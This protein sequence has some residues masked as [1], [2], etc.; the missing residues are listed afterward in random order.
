MALGD[1]PEFNPH[2][3]PLE[4]GDW[5]LEISAHLQSPNLQSPNLQSPVSNLQS[6]TDT[7]LDTDNDGLSDFVEVRV[8]TD[9]TFADTDEDGL[10]DARE[11]HGFTYAGKTWYLNPAA[12]DSN[13]DGLSDGQEWGLDASGALRTTP[14]DTD[15]DGV[16]DLFDPDNDN[17]G[18]P[19]R[20]D[21]SPFS[22]SANVATEADPFR[23]TVRNLTPNKPTFVDFQLRPTDE[24]HLWLAFNLLDWPDDDN[25]GQVIDIDGGTYADLAAAEGRTADPNE[26]NG[27][28]KLIPMLEIRLPAN[29]GNLP[30]AQDLEPYSIIVNNLTAD[31]SQQVAYVPLSLAVDSQ[32]GQRVAFTGRMRYLPTGSWPTAHEVRLAWVVQ[33]LVD[34]PCDRNAPD[35]AAI[36]CAADGYI[37]N[38]PQVV[39]S[40]YDEWTL[41]GL[42]VSEQHG[43]QTAIMYA[44][45][46]SLSGDPS[47]NGALTALSHALD[48][49]LLG[50]RDSDN[51]AQRDVDIATIAAQMP[52]LT[53][54]WGI[55]ETIHVTSATYATF[56]QAAMYTAMTDTVAVLNSAFNSAWTFDPAIMPTLLYA[57]EQESR[58]VSL[59]AL[60]AGSFYVNLDLNNL[61]VD[62]QPPSQPA[63]ER[64]TVAGLKWMHYCRATGSSQWNICPAAD[65]WATA[66]Q[67]YGSLALPG[68]P[69]D[70]DV[71]AGR[72]YVMQLYDL[73]L[74]QGVN[75]AVQ[76][77]N[78]LI[79]A[80]Y[81][82]KTDPQLA[83]TIRSAAGMGRMGA[84][85]IANT[86]F[87]ASTNNVSFTKQL[88][89]LFRPMRGGVYEGV[90]AIRNFSNPEL[91]GS[92][93][94]L[95]I[96]VLYVAGLL[97]AGILAA[98]SKGQDA[99]IALSALVIGLQFYFAVLDPILAALK[100]AGALRAAGSTASIA[101]SGTEV[102]GV[103]K[104]ASAVGTVIAIAVVWGFFIYSMAANSVSPF[105]AE[106]NRALA[107]TI[108]STIYLILLA[109]ISATVVGLILVGIIGLIDTILTAI[110]EL[111]VDDL[112]KVPGLGGACFTLGTTAVKL[113]AYA[114]YNYDVMIDTSARDLVAPGSPQTRLADPSKGFVAGNAISITMP[115]TTNIA[116]KSPDPAS[117]L[118]INSYL[119]FFSP[120][121][122]RSTTF[123]YSLTQPGPADLSAG[124][125]TMSGAWRNVREHHKYAATPMYGGYATTTPPEVGGFNLPAGINR[126]PSFYLNTGYALPAYE[127]WLVPAIP[128]YVPVCYTRTFTGKSSTK[129]ETLRYDIFPAT[130]AEFVAMT[131]KP[132]SGFG[133]AWD[134]RFPSLADADGDGLRSSVHGGLDP[135]DNLAAFGWDADRDGLVDA[136]ELARRS[137]G[138]GYSPIQ[139]DT[140]G[141]GLTDAQEAHYGTNPANRDSDNDG[142][143]DA[144]EVWHRVY[145]TTTCQPGDLWAGGWDV[146]INAATPFTVRVT[147][148][149][150]VADSDNDGISDLAE[151]QLAQQADPA[152]RLDDQNRPYHPG[153]PNSSP[154]AIF[155][156]AD[157]R[158]VQPGATVAVTHTVVTQAALAPSILD[159]AS[160]SALGASPAP[161]LLG[162]EPLTFSGAQ[163]VTQQTLLTA[164]PGL[165]TQAVAITSSVR[166]RLA[167]SGAATL[168]WEPLV[169]Q[170]L[171]SASPP[172]RRG[173]AIAPLRDR[174]DTFLTSA[175]LSNSLT[176]GG[177]GAIQTNAIPGG[178]A[179]TLVSDS[180]VSTRRGASAADI[181]CNAAGACMVVWEE[182]DTCN[183]LT[184]NDLRVVTSG[185]SGGIEPVIYWIADYTDTNPV[186]GG[187]Q[188]LWN[189]LTNGSR[190]MGSGAQRGPNANGFPIT[191]NVCGDGRIDVYEADTETITNNPSN[192]DLIGSSLRIGSD[193]RNM[194]PNLIV[195]FTR[196]GITSVVDLNLSMPRK[197]LDTI[198]GA[199][200]GPTGAVLRAPFAIPSA[201]PIS[202]SK[203]HNHRPV[204]ASDGFGFMVL[205]ELADATAYKTF[206]QWQ[207]FDANGQ[208]SEIARTIELESLRVA[209]PETSSLALDVVG[210][211]GGYRVARKFIRAF[212]APEQTIHLTDEIGA[213]PA[214]T[215]SWTVATTRAAPAERGAPVLAYN[216]R[217]DQTL[218]LYGQSANF[219]EVGIVRRMLYQGYGAQRTTVLADANLGMNQVGN[220]LVIRSEDAPH[221]V[222][223][224]VNDAWLISWTQPSGPGLG[225][226]Y[227][228]WRPDLV[229]GRI[230]GDQ[231]LA[232]SS[233]NNFTSRAQACPLLT[234]QVATDLRFEELPGASFFAD[235]SGRG[236]HATCSG[237][238]CPTPAYP[239]AVDNLGNAAGTPASDYAVRFDGVDDALT[240]NNPYAATGRADFTV[241]FWYKGGVTS[242]ANA[243][244]TVAGIDAS[245]N[246]L[247]RVQLDNRTGRIEF[248]FGSYVIGADNTGVND[249]R[250]HAIV[251]T[252]DDY[253]SNGRLA[254]Y[255]DGNATPIASGNSLVTTIPPATFRISGGGVPVY[256]DQFQV[257]TTALSAATVRDL[258]TR[259]LQAYC[260][261]ASYDQGAY[262][263]RKLA[264]RTPDVRGGKLT[265]SNSM[266][267]IVDGD[268]PTS[269]IDSVSHG[270]YLQGNTIHTIGGSAMDVTSGV[271]G[272]AVSVNGASFQP[273][274]GAVTWA[275]NLAVTEGSYT[276]QSRATDE[277]GN[278]GTPSSSVTIIADATPPIVTLNAPPAVAIAPTRNAAG[279]WI[280]A[281]SGAVADPNIGAQPGSGVRADAVEAR[282]IAQAGDDDAQGAGWQP[283]ILNGSGWSIDYRFA[284]ALLDP[285]GVYTIQLRATDNVGN[286][287]VNNNAGVLRL[288][289][290]APVATL[291][292]LDAVRQIITQTVTLSGVITDV[293]PAGAAA[294]EIAFTPLEQIAALPID[295][296]NQ[297]AETLLDAGGRVWLAGALT[298]TGA[299]VAAWSAP[300]PAGLEGEYQIDL[301]GRDALGNSRVAS[302]LWRGV[303]DTLAPRLAITAT[304][305]GA[306]YADDAGLR[307][308]EVIYTCSAEDRYLIE[309]EFACAGNAFQP[310]Q[311]FFT[312]DAALQALFPDRV[313]L[314]KLTNRYARWQTDPQAVEAMGACDLFGRCA[315]AD[316]QPDGVMAV[317]SAST[318]NT[319]ATPAAPNAVIVAPGNLRYVASNSA[320]PVTVVAEAEQG[321]RD[322]TLTL[323]G[324]VVHT[325]SFAQDALVTRVQRTVAVAAGVGAHTL[326]VR[327]TDW[328]GATQMDVHPVTFAVDA[329]PPAV[330]VDTGDL[331]QADAWQ[332]GSGVL[333]FRGAASDDVGLAAVQ[334]AVDA[335][336]FMNAVFGGGQWRAALPT[337][338]P[339]G[340]QLAVRVRAIDF[341]GQ[342]TQVNVMVNTNLSAPDAPDT[343]ITGVPSDPSADNEAIFTFTG[344]PG[345]REIVGFECQLDGG[346]FEPCFSPWRYDGLSKG[347]HHFRV[348]AIDAAGNVDLTP[349][350]YSWTVNASVLDATLTSAPANPSTQRSASFAFTGAGVGFECSLDG[351]PFAPCTS[352]QVYDGLAYGMHTFQVRARNA[353]GQ[354]GAAH[355]Y[356]WT[357]VNTPPVAFDQALATGGAPLPITLTA[358]DEDA[359]TFRVNAPAH[360]VLL[361]AP[362]ALTYIPD[363]GFGGVDSFTFVA[364]DGLADSNVATVTITVNNPPVANAQNVEVHEDTPTPITLSGADSDG[365]P[366]TYTV[367]MSPSFGLL[368]GAAPN[369]TYTPVLNYH[370]PDAFTFRV[371]DGKQDSDTATVAITVL[372][373]NDPPVVADDIAVTDE[374]IPVTIAVLANDNDAA[375]AGALDLAS[376]QVIAAPANGAA[377]VVNGAIVYAPSLDFNGVDILRYQ[378]CDLGYPLPALC[379]SA[380]VTVT[381]HAV[382][383]A[384]VA[385]PE[386]FTLNEDTPL[387]V[388]APGV[389]LNDRDPDIGDALIAV[390]VTPP[391]NGVLALNAN[392]AF[393]Y[394]PNPNYF[395]PDSFS[396]KARD[397]AGAESAVVTVMLTVN[398]VNDAPTISVVAGGVCFGDTPRAL[399]RLLVADVDNPAET[400]ILS[401]VSA[402]P[403]LVADSNIV[404]GGSGAERS[405]SITAS[406]PRNVSSGLVTIVVRDGQGAAA[407]TTLQVLVGT[408]KRETLTA[409]AGAS[410][411]FGLK[412]DDILVG[413]NGNDLLCGGS[414]NDRLEGGNGEDT[415]D[416]GAGR[417]TLLGGNGADFLTGGAGADFF[418]GGNGPDTATDFN[419]S[420]GDTHDGA[421]ESWTPV[422]TLAATEHSGDLPPAP[423]PAV[424]E[425][426]S[427]EAGETDEV[428]MTNYLF[429]PV[430]SQA[431]DE[432]IGGSVETPSTHPGQ[433][434]PMDGGEE[435]QL[436]V[437]AS[438]VSDPA[439]E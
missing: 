108:A 325:L 175:M 19:D 59:D 37:H 406:A 73:A 399:I 52:T 354:T 111:G 156:A 78:Q 144:E 321:V 390:L 11:V 61:Y 201:L 425:Q 352:P 233:A 412:G 41:T 380:T 387:V 312:I 88:G 129:I 350:S 258:Y 378:V 151:K 24:R 206:L 157:R 115:I 272:V 402:N 44:D 261:G 290:A 81:A 348:R 346:V 43:A 36:G 105:S 242:Q 303:I 437:D 356:M 13:G 202:I 163:T 158:Y 252:R 431:V 187:Y 432:T 65:Y 75:R 60:T 313:I 304:P 368:S 419:A 268:A 300:V 409:A 225:I 76:R 342:V 173:A 145:N 55:D 360:G 371:S 343:T 128:Y 407:T 200:V 245:N 259:S 307:R 139:C 50:A 284:D 190:D 38:V 45:P 127:C 344:I 12:M 100:W 199:L 367:V 2:V 194:D 306:S 320:L 34:L 336:P 63:V 241:A 141:D 153:V 429:L 376:L 21:L 72:I 428:L 397:A 270:Q 90:H 16:P 159:V 49:T 373:V 296:S 101:R 285:T 182:Q 318:L 183:T 309:E 138:V 123:N 329:Q 355:R 365:D 341:A 207:R 369:L 67:R 301:R 383:D 379:G 293:G 393:T 235:S 174:Q 99:R 366:L 328:A 375:D 405:M 434:A 436:P 217:T 46:A 327:A 119:Y 168:A 227:S 31:G 280:A 160:G 351:A 179:G 231:K 333:R 39:Q 319:A 338:D 82:L 337:V 57:Y 148:N 130:F 117:G 297:Q 193:N 299:G 114:L 265:T 362:P 239:G 416:G 323:D 126:T 269:S 244:F 7:G 414:G 219:G 152:K 260:I 438:S 262:T 253:A 5:R 250:W 251:A 391:D 185:E 86:A 430:I 8:G 167:P 289:G 314:S 135:N 384:P 191:V 322:V 188:L 435:M 166:A 288:D 275:H 358:A 189:P 203:S 155:L 339:E 359:L 218:L 48:E 232:M 361:G 161:A 220:N 240:L 221:A 74:T 247:V 58:G 226:V 410:V 172:A 97:T 15:D 134:A 229:S 331:T 317:M 267:L 254:L 181:A 87:M 30:P 93:I 180:G 109:L 286:R 230:I 292:D 214:G 195:R 204:V 10:S 98:T 198:R 411:V 404:F 216:P 140:D 150:L 211:Q 177:V 302:N 370:G 132:D 234:S 413:G 186:D 4:T 77:N 426:P 357:I 205:S 196:S 147:S 95:G 70:P 353:A 169:S 417:D 420:E 395:G 256:L 222:Y 26:A 68:D 400:L 121:N 62:F 363:S 332:V 281:L 308:Y 311:R 212:D 257:Y 3:N 340:R 294:V 263:W 84:V 364:N 228:F 381:I 424:G 71:Q 171:G 6:L 427:E 422:A 176:R 377:S 282:L 29:G 278:V 154:I 107:E 146:T 372:P 315:V 237:G 279:Q 18:V 136:F 238:A 224:A 137:E 104:Q 110:C 120:S 246:T 223:D 1:K 164:L 9:P 184:I 287:T 22:R 277:A 433:V 192:L 266:T 66:E 423:D 92:A 106:F 388:A 40:Y 335:Q 118:I 382:N 310:P 349:A 295:V 316:T 243:P 133:L 112:R 249:G 305:T 326:T 255:L 25:Q 374:D 273:A 170:V 403:G 51:D 197:N 389:L 213:A 401:G 291:S 394:T 33:M 80:N 298:P 113:I 122:L 271:A 208:P 324:I 32:T 385:N 28:M 124:L 103:S 96:K 94:V 79:A 386:S 131:S 85:F 42:N 165:A 69:N 415:L 102:L 47:N 283:A 398:P 162:F 248:A 143:T 408:D 14:L 116:H 334:I 392:G 210:V 345:G 178:E 35:A 236:N 27:D 209:A 23:L 276:L 56:D 125:N 53:T 149:P 330:T 54:N 396:Y 421:V 20:M 347:A 64:V 142:L 418:S 215:E 274:A 264:L 91:R 89:L 17:D 83:T 439:E